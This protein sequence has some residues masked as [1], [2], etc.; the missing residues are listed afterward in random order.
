MDERLPF[1]LYWAII[2]APGMQHLLLLSV[3]IR[4]WP[5]YFWKSRVAVPCNPMWSEVA[6]CGPMWSDVVLCAPM[7]TWSDVVISHTPLTNMVPWA[8][9]SPQPK[10]HLSRFNHFGRT[11][12]SE[13]PTDR[14][15]YSVC[16]NNLPNVVMRCSLI[17]TS[18]QSNLT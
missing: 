13:R 9:H 17:I 11:H 10:W 3:T 5:N 15:H 12:D 18:G 7:W 2:A 4:L 8:H 16:N 6:Q 1:V 14:P